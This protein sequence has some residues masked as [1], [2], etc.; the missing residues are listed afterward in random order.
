MG[1]IPNWGV[2]NVYGL[3]VEEEFLPAMVYVSTF[4]ENDFYRRVTSGDNKPWIS[5]ELPRFA[6]E[7]LANWLWH[8]YLRNPREINRARREIVPREVRAETAVRKLKEMDEFLISKQDLHVIFISPK[9]KQTVNGGPKDHM[10]ESLLEKYS[11]G[12][13]Y[14]LDDLNLL[15]ASSE[16]KE[17]WYQDKAHLTDDGHLV[18][19]RLMR[20]HLE[21]LGYL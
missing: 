20:A 14:L 12:V 6:L 1:G 4:I 9:R 19:G 16:E 5:Y 15:T 3:I 17:G 21:K 2:E 18:W 13:I 7:E 11:V 10:V 8:R